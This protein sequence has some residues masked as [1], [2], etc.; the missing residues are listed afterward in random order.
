[1][2]LFMKISN[3]FG[4]AL[5]SLTILLVGCGRDS[6]APMRHQ[7]ISQDPLIVRTSDG[8]EWIAQN[9]KEGNLDYEVLIPASGSSYPKYITSEYAQET[10]E[11]ID[12][13]MVRELTNG[14]QTGIFGQKVGQTDLSYA[15]AEERYLSKKNRE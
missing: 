8:K 12:G 10:G 5:T 15:I 4:I 13:N 14:I 2:Y 6:E 7:Y 11:V 1:M 9:L 3:T